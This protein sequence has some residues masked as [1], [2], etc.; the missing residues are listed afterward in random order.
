[1]EA[2]LDAFEAAEHNNKVVFS[3]WHNGINLVASH[4]SL[5]VPEHTVVE[6]AMP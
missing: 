4:T 5:T 3:L 6:A 1:M 2:V